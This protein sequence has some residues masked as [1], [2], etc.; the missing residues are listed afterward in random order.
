[1]AAPS[2][3]LLVSATI[4]EGHNATGRA[5]EEAIRRRWPGC[6][7][8]WVDALE[9]MGSWVPSTFGSIYVT[10]V[11]STPWLYDFFYASLWRSRL[12]AHGCRRFIGAWSG[13]RLRSVIA[14]T[15]PDLIVSTYPMGTAG[16]SWLRRRGE[17][18]CPV[19]AIVSDFSPHPLWIYSGID[20]HYV[21][22]E[23]SLRE[24]HRAEP[25]AISAACA[26]PVVSAFRPR[27]KAAARR[28][29]HLPEDGFLVLISCGSLGFGS[30]ERA[31]DAA[32]EADRVDRVVVACGRNDALRERLARR[33]E[34]RPRLIPLG[35]V[36][37][38][39]TLTA[40][41]DVVV[42]NAG[43]AT[44]LE[45]LACGRAVVM[46]EPIAGHG[47]ANAELMAHAGLAE[48]CPREPDLLTS[49]LRLST[50]PN[51]LSEIE[52]RARRH[53]R[54][55]DFDQQIE[56]LAQLPRPEQ[57]LRPQDAFFVYASTP[58]VSQQTGAV[59]CLSEA[60]E[61]WSTE[62][63]YRRLVELI[64]QRAL[65]LPM[66]CRRLVR[67]RWRAPT[68]APVRTLDAERHV[69]YQEVR[70]PAGSR[71]QWEST[72]REFFAAPLRTDCPPWELLL[73][74]DV[75]SKRTALLAKLHHALGDGVAVTST[76]VRLLSDTDDFADQ[77]APAAPRES[78]WRQGREVLRGLVSLARSGSTPATGYEGRSTGKREFAWVELPAATVRA[79]KRAHGVSTTALLLAVVAE[80]L[81]RLLDDS[82][83]TT[84]DQRFRVMLP[85]TTRT[86]LGAV[87]A[88]PLGNRTVALSID[89]PVGPM[90]AQRRVAEV[91]QRLGN[92]GSNGQAAA[93]AA[94]LA[95]AGAL[96]APLHSWVAS[97]VYRRRFFNA[98]VS[99]MPGLRH[100]VSTSGATLDGVFPV[101]SLADGVGVA[102]GGI[103][104]C[105]MVGFGITA[106]AGLLADVDKLAEHL[107]RAFDEL[108]EVTDDTGAEQW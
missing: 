41:A 89:L 83:G 32:L 9:V 65:T 99:V 51:R 16:L 72:L 92:A 18:N 67:R 20:L 40:C 26:P 39:A 43:G 34:E 31:V 79:S 103:T 12:F 88:E 69:R 108:A 37:D 11:E 15:R 4:G 93:S 35:W 50:N 57:P 21:M 100:P 64:D 46:F 85:K 27:D 81:H 84:P 36:Q 7:V 73:V 10:N 14:E 23:T 59:L 68:W 13:R 98:V 30:V 75:A 44:A 1:M 104:W 48:L 90:S 6:S 45:A 102:I 17:L 87:E 54:S 2:R 63:Y 61:G 96:P 70:D 77:Q 95:A 29:S 91:A 5:A 76:L 3:V 80:A 28:E 94:V 105:D 24:A 97:R 19:A 82:N 58:V 25:R 74:R 60:R 66:L 55:Y 78:W 107:H 62:E 53:R 38:M 52:A 8:A 86:I 49:L 56:N 42:S 33:A 47:R 106:D 22:S 71:S 101:L